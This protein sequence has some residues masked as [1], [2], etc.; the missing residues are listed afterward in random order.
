MRKSFKSGLA[1]AGYAA[2]TACTAFATAAPARAT[3]VATISGCYDCGVFDTASLIFNNTTGGT[4]THATMVLTGYQGLNKG[5]T[6][7]VQLGTL[8]SGNTQV[9]W[10]SLPGVSSATS[11]GVL[12]AYDYD[13][14]YIGTPNIIND[15]SCGGAGCAPG[16]GPQWYA[17]VGNFSVVFTALVSGGSYDGANVYSVF[18]PNSNVTGSFVGWQGLDQNGY[19]ESPVYD[20]HSGVVTGDMA[21]IDLGLPPPAGT[22]AEPASVGLVFAALAALSLATRRRG[23]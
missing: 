23:A 17:D 7:T 15:P 21:N 14:Q 22:V 5:L 9:Y 2:I 10:G 16:G 8:A 6:A 20:V 11:P 4:L 12:T 13:D 18:S 19:S 3:T 1:V